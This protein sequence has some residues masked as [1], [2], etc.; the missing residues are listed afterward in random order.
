MEPSSRRGAARCGR[1]VESAP[2][3]TR[4]DHRYHRPRRPSHVGVPH[5]PRLPS[6]RA[7]ARPSQPQ[8]QARARREPRARARRGRPPRPVVADRRRRA[9]ATRRGLQP[10]RH[11]LRGALVPPARAHR[12]HHRPRRAAHARGHPHRRRRRE[13]PDSLLPSVVV[14]DVR[15]GAR[16]AAARRH[17]IPPALAV[18]RREGVRAPHDDQLPRVLRAAR[19]VGHLLQPRRPP[20]RARVRHPQDHQRH[21]P[22]Q[23]RPPRLDHARQRRRG[24]T[25]V[26]P[27]TSSRPCGSCSSRTSPTT[28]SSQPARPTP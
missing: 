21:R 13:Q 19:V 4:P 23:A 12:R 10:R 9:G 5:R 2:H 24:A 3:E 22:H 17:R 25:G 26:T 28:T 27:A 18:R 8:G 7:R 20:S 11:E 16:D 1:P 15:Q 14:G 6:L